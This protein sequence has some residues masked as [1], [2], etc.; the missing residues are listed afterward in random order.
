MQAL[1][2]AVAVAIAA[3][4]ASGCLRTTSFRC[5][6]SAE[7]TGTG[8]T[9]EPVGYCSFTDAHCSTGRRYGEL[10][11]P[12]AGRCVGDEPSVDSGVDA[13]GPDASRGSCPAAYSAIGSHFYGKLG[14]AEW[15]AQRSACAAAAPGTY[16]VVPDDATELGAVL[17]LAG[18]DI[19]VGI[20]D[21]A[22]EGSFVTVLNAPAMF[23]PWGSAQPDNAPGGADCV[24]AH[25]DARY[26]DDRCT[27]GRVA[28]CEC[29]PP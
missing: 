6:S 9:C 24:S 7:C 15:T 25:A 8:G 23:L 17:A 11:G 29:A 14:A 26:Y 1:R 16:L 19:W 20:N 28:V 21:L 5:E 10:S 13:A 18:A 12:Y 27:T 22:V 4:P 2:V 3:G